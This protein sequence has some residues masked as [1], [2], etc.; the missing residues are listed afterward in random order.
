MADWPK[1]GWEFVGRAAELSVLEGAWRAAA[2]ASAPVVVV[3]GEPGIGKT[4]MVAELARRARA[5]DAEVLWGTFYEGG[6]TSP[7]GAWNEATERFVTRARQAGSGIG[8]DGRWLAPLAPASSDGGAAPEAVPAQVARLRMAEALARLFDWQPL[9][10]VV[11][12]DDAQWAHPDA[13]ELLHHVAR[14]ARETLIVVIF[15]GGALALG[16]PLARCLAEIG[17]QRPCEYVLLDGLAARE[18]ADLLGQAAGEALDATAVAGLYRQSGG[19]P[20]FLVELGRFLLGRD[21]MTLEPAARKLLPE[22]IRAAVGLRVAALAPEARQMLQLASVFTAGFDFA[23]LGALTDLEEGPLLDCLD[24]AL[25]AE[26]VRPVGED[27]YDF[28]H[29]LVRQT[30]YELS[31]PSRRVR[32]HRRLAETLERLHAD[33]LTPVAGELVRQYHASAG[34]AGAERGAAFASTAAASA[35]AAQA[36]ADAVIALR[37]GLELLTGDDGEA[38]AGLTAELALAEAEAGLVEDAAATLAAAVDLLE[39]GGA[40][41]DEV[42]ALVYAVAEAFWVAPSGVVELKPLIG[43]ALAGLGDAHTLAWA[44]LTLLDHFVAP[45]AFGPIPVLGWLP[46]DPEAVRIAREEGTEADYYLTLDGWLPG[47]GAELEDL[48]ARVDAWRDPVARLRALVPIVGYLALLEPG[49]SADADRLAAEFVAVA[50]ELGLAP[51]RV[52]A[53]VFVAALAGGRGEFEAAA[54]AIGEAEDLAAGEAPGPSTEAL[55]TLVRELTAQNRGADWP[56]LARSM[57]DLS[58]SAEHF[59][60]WLGLACAAFAAKAF[61]LA[62]EGERAREVLGHLLPAVRV[63]EPTASTTANAVGLAGAAIWELGDADLAATLLPTA[64]LLAADR[65]D[66]YMTDANLTV[67]RLNALGGDPDRAREFFDRAR[68]SLER[69]RQWPLR[70]IVDHDEARMRIERGEVGAAP[71]LASASERFEEL[72]MGEWSR[73]VAVLAA[74]DRV[75]P[76]Q[77]TP[78]EAEVLRLVAARRSNKEIA[79]ELVLSVHTVERHVQN[80]YRKIGATNRAAAGDYVARVSL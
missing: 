61:A 22:S 15:R 6:A 8:A 66:F 13:L 46:F 30:L 4:R 9:P 23:E 57:W 28:S 7:Y 64:E 56:A 71:L 59:S 55:M 18:G 5:E 33:D 70:A 42:A 52:I 51:H 20:Y 14:L 2:S 76:D 1:S 74:A 39:G 48:V 11:V 21:E 60:G 27:R 35:R 47:F 72:G 25:A 38:R 54:A 58:R 10:P 16:H 40:S 19:N 44:R 12:L 31:S 36:P 32:L 34:L 45:E 77:L 3:H 62:G 69:R 49:G 65:R 17:R 43:R 53:R 73:R 41:A 37:L 29:A 75:L 50:A 80:A 26:L 24:G 78:R 63:D 79:A 67:A 68:A